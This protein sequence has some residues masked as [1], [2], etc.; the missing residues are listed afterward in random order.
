[1]ERSPPDGAIDL[2]Y[3]LQGT[4]SN[5]GDP[6]SLPLG[7]AAGP[8]AGDVFVT[9]F[10]NTTDFPTT[11]DAPQPFYGSGAGD[12]FIAKIS[13]GGSTPPPPTNLALNK[14][15]VRLVRVLRAVRRRS[16]AVDG[17]MSTRWSSQF[18]D[19]QWIYVDLGQTYAI[20]RVIL[21]WET[22]YGADYQVQVSNDATNWTTIRAVT[23]GDGGVDDLAGVS[24][25]G[26]YV[27]IYGTQRGTEWGY[28]LWE[29]EVY[30]N[31]TTPPPSDIALDKPVVTSSDFSAQYAGVSP[32]TA[33]ARRAG[34]A[35]FSDPQWIYVDLG[36]RYA[37]NRVK[38]AWE[39]AYGADFQ[40]Q[41]SDDAVSWRRSRPSQTTTHWPT[42]PGCSAVGR[43]VRMFGTRRGTEWGYSLFSFEVYG[44]PAPRS[45]TARSI[46]RRFRAATS[47]R[48]TPRRSRSTAIRRRA[49]R[50]SSATRSGSTSTSA[51][52]SR[53]T[54]SCSSW[55]TAYGADYEIQMSDDASSWSNVASVTDNT[56]GVND[57]A[58]SGTGR[59][60]RI[61]G[62]RRGTEWGYSLWSFEVY[63]NP[64]L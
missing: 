54:R 29:L 53:S 11:A 50:A 30:G 22:A 56:G 59:Y 20:N 39:A 24:G 32:W 63:G 55:E 60:V 18:S 44:D 25:T 28:S 6:N 58:L 2:H 17:D 52:G 46:D 36:Q 47:R 4:H 64:A 10:T 33:T 19:P 3:F 45:P 9:G 15:V 57:L 31:R 27:R 61:Y 48:R 21:R 12:A 49:G 42:I 14:A 37:V 41:I 34:R 43:Y 51:S 40:I 26:R 16:F 35:P 8:I 38:L 23:G 62:T 13:F 7:I 5:V 1:M